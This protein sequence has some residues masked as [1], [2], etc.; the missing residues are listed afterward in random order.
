MGF[1]F[2]FVKN[3]RKR[4]TAVCRFRVEKDCPWRIQAV[5]DATDG[6]FCISSYDRTH[7]CGTV[8]GAVSR[9]RLNHHIIT[10]IIID[11]IRSMPTLSPAQVQA[12]VKKNYGGRN[13]F[14]GIIVLRFP[15][16]L[17]ILMSLR[18]QIRGV[19]CI[20]M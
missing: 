8:F 2:E 14:L 16:C 11:D 3:G 4:V 17:R 6:A 12:V 15:G 7:T 20:W 13:L 9:K 18:L 10:D 5:E 1:E 19:M